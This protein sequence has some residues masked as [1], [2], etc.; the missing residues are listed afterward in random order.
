MW[1]VN[2]KLDTFWCLPSSYI[3]LRDG[4]LKQVLIWCLNLLIN[5]TGIL[6]ADNKIIN[7]NSYLSTSRYK[8]VPEFFISLSA[9]CG[10]IWNTILPLILVMKSESVKPA[11]AAGVSSL[12]VRT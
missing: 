1:S 6:S 9:S 12:T 11:A 5:V 10:D 7:V 3:N 8:V 4:F 2:K